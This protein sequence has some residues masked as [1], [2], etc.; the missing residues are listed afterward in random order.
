MG[1]F[2][3]KAHKIII[4]R[5]EIKKMGQKIIFLMKKCCFCILNSKN[6][7]SLHHDNSTLT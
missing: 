4:N 2:F 7:V 6:V 1:L 5:L 3:K